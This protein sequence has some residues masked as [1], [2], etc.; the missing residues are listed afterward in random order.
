[1]IIQE[2]A[3]LPSDLVLARLRASSAGLSTEE[4]VKRIATFG[5][6]AL[7]THHA[8]AFVVL[9]RQFKNPI[10]ILL[11]ATVLVSAYLGD[12]ANSSVIVAILLMSVGLGFITE[13]RA[14]RASEALHSRVH[15]T[16]LTRRDGHLAEIDVTELVPGD[17]V[18]LKLGSVVPADIRIIESN[19]FE[20]D[21]SIITGESLPV[22]KNNQPV[23]GKPDLLN[24]D[25]AA[26]M[27]TVVHG[28]SAMGVVVATASNTEFG[29]IALQLGERQPETDFQR[30][31]RRFS[32]FLLWVAL[33]LTT[34][35]FIG[36][37][38]L[39]RPLIESLMFSLAI[40][41]GMTPQ[42][43]PAVVSTGL[44]LGS[45]R[46]A[47]LGVMVKQLVSIEDLGDI[48]ILVTDK[49]GTLTDGSITFTNQVQIG[50]SDV[51]LLGLLASE[52]DYSRTPKD[53]VG[54]SALDGALWTQVKPGMLT[55]YLRLAILP[56]NHETRM[57][58]ALVRDAQGQNTLVTK[59]SAEDVL[60]RCV[61]VPKQLAKAL[62]D[63]Y[64]AGSRVVLV[65]SRPANELTE[66]SDASVKKLEVAG[67]LVFTDRPK[68]SAAE[69]L[70]Q[71][72]ELGITV[73]IATGDN[74]VVAQKVCADLGL[75]AGTVL[76]GV[77][78]DAVSDDDLPALAMEAS[79]FARVSPD[80]KARIIRALRGRGLSVGFMGDGVNDAMA[81]HDADVGISVDSGADVAK[82]AANVVLLEK[83]LGVLAAGVRE[84]RRTFSNTM[85]YVFM[86][87]SGDFGNMFSASIGSVALNFLPMSPSQVLLND[88]LYDSSQ[89]AIPSDR[90]DEEQIAKPSHW[91]IKMIRKF[92]LVF[93]PIS[94][95]F[96]FATFALMLWVFHAGVAEFQSGW[97]IESLATE[98][99]IVFAVRTRR[100]PF[101]RSRP[102]VGLLLSVLAVVGIGAYLPYSPLADALG[103]SPLPAPFF[104]AL[105]LMILLYLVLVET[106]KRRFFARIVAGHIVAKRRVISER[107][108]VGRR[109]GRFS[110]RPTPNRGN[111][112]A[113]A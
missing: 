103:F 19:E 66:L 3:A 61:N 70:R 100:V 28:G 112:K 82:D 14:E 31:L 89:L 52:T 73:K 84:G 11:V 106:A 63:E 78:I 7:R 108:R 26:L 29:R 85:K 67:L 6:N 68:D 58:S 56:F 97:F 83:D 57:A 4:A 51:L 86:G 80:Q 64:D 71:L 5:P 111:R 35:I 77:D 55:G 107:H 91:D 38:L 48:D 88:M 92:M 10:L 75:P 76:T 1:M 15:H 30:G 59:G 45:K 105:V 74:A 8:R 37:L 93:G 98:T 17:I 54:L 22:T 25:S 87:T 42:L 12:L 44:A 20:C 102:S 79:I 95:L 21:E 33:A 40:A 9:V 39:Q 18:H 101:Y 50:K 36:N 16:V 23:D 13:Y 2:A 53:I 60:A 110:H 81:L 49:T 104:I 113:N 41:V 27:G 99:L 43:L 96:D 90:V 24:L 72:A 32:V 69:S 47:K 94:S 46:L 65:A 34:L 109:A 62:Q